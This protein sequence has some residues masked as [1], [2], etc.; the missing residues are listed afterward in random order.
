[1]QGASEAVKKAVEF[2]MRITRQLVIQQDVKTA[3]QNRHLD[4]MKTAVD[5]AKTIQL[6]TRQ[7]KQ[8]ETELLVLQKEALKKITE[9]NEKLKKIRTATNE[10]G[11]VGAGS[12]R[13][14]FRRPVTEPSPPPAAEEREESDSYVFR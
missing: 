7:F 13:F 10:D 2:Q 14:L 4:E 9:E 12:K 5:K 6:K 3:L 8:L 1:L 11:G